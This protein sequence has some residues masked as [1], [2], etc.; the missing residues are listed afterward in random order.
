MKREDLF[1]TT[2][3]WITD[4]KAANVHKSIDASL[5]ELQLYYIDLLLLHKA[6]FCNLPPEAEDEEEKRQHGD[7]HDHVKMVPD[8]P[9]YRLGYNK[10]NLK[11]TWQAMEAAC[12]EVR[13]CLNTSLYRANFILLVFPPSP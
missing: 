8:D 6:A 9:K 13:K 5:K 11:E 12:D 2:K 10:D 3:L 4:W 1:I 7:F